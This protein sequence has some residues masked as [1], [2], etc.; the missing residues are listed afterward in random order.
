LFNCL[1]QEAI[2]QADRLI[3]TMFNVTI[4]S[5]RKGGVHRK[6]L[7]QFA[8]ALIRHDA[9]VLSKCGVTNLVSHR[10]REAARKANIVDARFPGM[11]P[12]LVIVEWGKI[13]QQNYINR[14]KIACTRAEGELDTAVAPLHSTMSEILS[15]VNKLSDNQDKLLTENALLKSQVNSLHNQVNILKGGLSWA[16]DRL[17]TIHKSNVCMREVFRTPDRATSS[18]SVAAIPPPPS[19]ELSLDPKDTAITES[20]NLEVLGEELPPAGSESSSVT[21]PLSN[22]PVSLDPPISA[23]STTTAHLCWNHDAEQQSKAKSSDAGLNL[24]D[25]LIE[26]RDRGCINQENISKSNVPVGI[27]SQSNRTYVEYCLEFVQ[28]VGSKDP[29]VLNHIRFFVDKSNN[30][31]TELRNAAENIVSECCIALKDIDSKAL[32]KRQFLAWADAFESTR[33]K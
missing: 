32:E 12:E 1:G 28:F 3:D 23:T 25:V 27:C 30:N 19:M 31:A 29:E 18:S 15:A 2:A 9:E 26:L 24:V 33:K 7:Q 22:V 5:F 10:L 4:E 13:I 16:N 8:L 17:I 20:F 6:V 14:L 21:I 11:C